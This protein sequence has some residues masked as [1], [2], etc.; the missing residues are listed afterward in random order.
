M[1]K[2]TIVGI[3]KLG[4]GLALLMENVGF[5][6]CGVDIFSDY[7]N[8]LNNKTFYSDEPGYNE[9]IQNNKNFFGTTSLLEG[10]NHS[11]IIFIVVQTP[12]GG[13]SKFYD[14]SILSNLLVKI[15]NLNVENKHI[16]IGCTIM[17][18]YINEIGK[19]LI[20]DCK[21]TSLSYNPEFIAQ[22]DIINGFKNPDIILIG[23][24]NSEVGDI[25][26]NIYDKV[27]LNKPKYCVLKPI[28][29]EIVKISIN[30][31]ITTK[32]SFAN[33]ISDLCDTLNADKYKVLKSIGSDSRIGNKYFNPGYSFGGPCFPKI[34]KHLKRILDNNNINSNLLSST[35]EYNQEHIEF[36]AKQLL[37]ENKDEYIIENV[38]FKENSRIPIIEE[39]PKLK[40]AE[41][42]V[43]H[44]KKVTIKDYDNLIIQVKKE[45]GNIF[46]YQIKY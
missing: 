23:T 15:N 34:L 41:Y 24:E 30:G 39:S 35:S 1:K 9:L 27:V 7:I 44:G 16:I 4:L 29:A 22:G 18:G 26:K 32:L 6:V 37:K 28:E 33:I 19:L 31:F 40:I 5:D 21:N 8:N 11:D 46:N 17:P 45:Y 42:I 3:G 38:C 36:Q 20:S 12:N 43:K 14:H 25:L 10:I 2:I 13:D